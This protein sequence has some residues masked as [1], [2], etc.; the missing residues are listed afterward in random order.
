[1]IIN[2]KCQNGVLQLEFTPEKSDQTI[3]YQLSN[4]YKKMNKVE[5]TST[6]CEIHLPKDW[7]IEDS[8]PDVFALAMLSIIYPFC[9]SEMK[10]PQGVSKDFHD[11]VFKITKKKVLPVNDKLSPRKAPSNSVPALAFSGGIDSTAAVLLLPEDTHLFYIDRITPKGTR[12]LLNQEAAY[13]AC[14]AMADLGKMVHKIKTDLQYLRKPVGFNSF[15]ADVVPALLLADYYGFD[16]I[17]NGHTLEEGY[18]I[19]YLGYQDCKDTELINPWYSLLVKIDMPYT[20][21]T[22]GLSE[23]C[24]TTIVK[25]SPYHEFAQACS[26][27]KI[28]KPCM[29]CYKCFRKSLLEKVLENRPIHDRF[30]DEL[31]KI[32]DVKWAINTPHL[33]FSNVI[34][35]ITAHYSGEHKKMLALKKKTRGDR[36]NVEWMHK[37]YPKAEEFL[38]PKYRIYVKKQ[39]YKYVEPMNNKDI[40]TMKQSYSKAYFKKEQKKTNL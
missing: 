30:L 17:A 28:K 38:A 1:M 15:L 14:D 25:R 36:L 29:N 18:R 20:L 4:T 34:S 19:G 5:M 39:I 10:L 12:T 35:Y 21:P 16:S 8:H 22:I 3:Q 33:H 6:R 37:W 2:Y 13:Y 27:G 7:T 24:T 40:Q 9:G 23:V 11:Q 31:F 32:K 26:R